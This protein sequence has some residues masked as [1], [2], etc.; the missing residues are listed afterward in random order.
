[1]KRLLLMSTVLMAV[2]LL[3][4][5]ASA[6]HVTDMVAMG[7][8]DG[9][10][11]QLDVHFRSTAEFLD[12]HYEVAVMDEDMEIVM[13]SGDMHVVQEGEQDITILV[14]DTFDVILD[15]YF[16]VMG[17]FTLTSP[18]PD[19]MDEDVVTFENMI[20]CGSVGT[21]DSSF[22]NIKAMYR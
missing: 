10:T 20:E 5:L 18:Y 7:D 12:L 22:E 15:G 8:C 2:L 16:V 17:T 11:A 13:V 4:A 19:G 3:P 21:D 9:F 14:S 1:M 6:T